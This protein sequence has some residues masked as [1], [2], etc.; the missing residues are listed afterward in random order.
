MDA[1]RAL[2]KR[3]HRGVAGEATGEDVRECAMPVSPGNQENIL[4]KA[5][6]KAA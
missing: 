6:V 3:D 4:R 2:S 5:R 1:G